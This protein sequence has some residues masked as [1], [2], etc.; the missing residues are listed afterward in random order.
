MKTKSNNKIETSGFLQVGNPYI[1]RECMIPV[2]KRCR[3]GSTYCE[4][5][6][7]TEDSCVDNGWVAK[8]NLF[9]KVSQKHAEEI[10]QQI[11]NEIKLAYEK[12]AR[13]ME[14]ECATRQIAFADI[15]K[16]NSRTATIGEIREAAIKLPLINGEIDVANEFTQSYM[17]GAEDI[18]TRFLS[19]LDTLE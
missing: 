3:M 2:C 13:E 17:N 5:P 9:G 6:L 18:Q 7:P 1:E 10:N 8:L 12:G 14:I 4:C 11:E 16:S 15:V 19:I